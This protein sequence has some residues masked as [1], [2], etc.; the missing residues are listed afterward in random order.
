MHLFQIHK[1]K[2]KARIW[3]GI[4][5]AAILLAGC[6]KK[7]PR[8]SEEELAALQ[9]REN[10]GGGLLRRRSIIRG[11]RSERKQLSGWQCVLL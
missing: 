9:Y 7:I 3:F 5:M 2:R 6:G 1:H 4:S 10:G 11:L 8:L